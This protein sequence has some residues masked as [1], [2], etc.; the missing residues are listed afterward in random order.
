MVVRSVADPDPACHFNAD[1]DSTFFFT[2]MHIRIQ[3]LIKNAENLETMAYRLSTAL[4]CAATAPDSRDSQSFELPRLST[5]MRICVRIFTIEANLDSDPAS[6]N[7][8][9]PCSG[10]ATLERVHC[11]RTSRYISSFFKEKILPRH[12]QGFKKYYFLANK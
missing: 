12:I 4:L 6:K 8:A 2:L 10:S 7:D 5:L 1:P 9:D 11:Y 3:L